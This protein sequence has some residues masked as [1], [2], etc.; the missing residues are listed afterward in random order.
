MVTLLQRLFLSVL[1]L[2]LA[3]C[4]GSSSSLGGAASDNGAVSGRAVKGVVSDGVVEAFAWQAGSWQSVATGFTDQ[5]GFFDLDLAAVSGPVLISITAGVDTRVLCDAVNGCDGALFGEQMLP[6]SDFRLLAILPA[7]RPDG[8]IA[9]TPLTHLAAR[10]V[11]QLAIDGVPISDQLITLALDRV[12]D[13]FDLPANFAFSTPIDITDIVERDGAASLQH[14]L[15]G[16]SFATLAADLAGTEN[17]LQRVLD[18]YADSFIDLAGQ[19]LL[20]SDSDGAQVRAGLDL[21]RDAALLTAQSL[22]DDGQRD[23]LIASLNGLLS[24]WG[25]NPMSAAGGTTS[26]DQADFDQALVLLDDLDLYLTTAGIDASADFLA[27]EIQ[28]VNW[29][30]Q[31]AGARADTAGLIQVAGEAAIFSL[32]ASFSEQLLAASLPPGFPLPNLVDLGVVTGLAPPGYASYNRSSRVLTLSGTRHGQ[33]VDIT[34][35]APQLLFGQ[36]IEYN[37]SHAQVSNATASGVLSGTLGINIAGLSLE[38]LLGGTLSL[39]SLA[40]LQVSVDLDGT[41]SLTRESA[42][43]IAELV[44]PGSAFTVALSA[45]GA[46]DIASFLQGGPALTLQ[47]DDGSLLS[48]LGDSLAALHDD[49]FCAGRAP[50]ML[51][52]GSDASAEA[53]FTFTAFGLPTIDMSLAG[54]LT[55]LA[56]LVNS[57]IGAFADTSGGLPGVV[58]QIDPSLL[59]L[60]GDARLR[61]LDS[62]RGTRDYQ[63]AVVNNRLDAELTNSGQRLQFYVTSL[64]GGYI[65]VGSTLVATV[66]F[67]WSKLGATVHR[68]DGVQRSYFLGPIA[69]AIEPELVQLLL[70]ALQGLLSGLGGLVP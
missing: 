19:L 39:E 3:A 26:F 10:W 34:L 70:E 44:Q 49:S 64:N 48:P 62:E 11:E 33:N 50:L 54:E 35:T 55:G 23:D 4:G 52:A 40:N 25:E 61:V 13:I 2:L 68:V 1:I 28:Q 36:R 56:D 47:I 58:E 15:L 46:L 57:I 66:T 31:Q 59:S 18:S 53:C 51:R 5:Q 42:A 29:L 69:D 65:Y 22:L 27:T 43:D 24:R 67:D 21:L 45:G 14:A 20:L 8:T 63:F 17:A 32:L 12:A 9:V 6:G 7:S 41:A 60:L 30:Y 16:A 38:Q 37:I